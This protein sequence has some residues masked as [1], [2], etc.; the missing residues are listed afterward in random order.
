MT[1]GAFFKRRAA[2]IPGR[3]ASNCWARLPGV[4]VQRILPSDPSGE[5]LRLVEQLEGQ[6]KP[7]VQHG[8]WFSGDGKRALLV[9]QTRAAGYDID[10]QER[11]LALIR[12]AHSNAVAGMDAAAAPRLLLTGPG[13]FSVSTRAQIKGDAWRFSLIAT[14]LV[15]V[16]LLAL[17]RSPRVLVLGL[18]PV[19]SGALA[20]VAAVSLGLR[21]GARHHA[22]VWR[23]ADRRGRGL[24][25]LSVHPDGPG[26][27][28]ASHAQAYLAD[29]AAGRDDFGLRFR[30]DAFFRFSGARAARSF[31]DRRTAGGGHASHDGCFPPCC[32]PDSPCTRLRRSRPA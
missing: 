21:L 8:V 6:T 14:S 31:F 28:A 17:Y 23:H 12:A 5:L 13:V 11:A 4:F 32:P 9:A 7:S 19:A 25:D 24:R 3:E 26:R 1:P 2:R 15:A 30:R 18:L 27:L 10:A 29:A 20:G 22:R 16:M